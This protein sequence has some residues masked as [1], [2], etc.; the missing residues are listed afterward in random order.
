MLLLKLLTKSKCYHLH[1]KAGS[2]ILNLDMSDSQISLIHAKRP[3]PYLCLSVHLQLRTNKESPTSSIHLMWQVVIQ[4]QSPDCASHLVS[5]LTLWSRP[6]TLPQPLLPT[7]PWLLLG[8]VQPPGLVGTRTGQDRQNRFWREGMWLNQ[9][10]RSKLLAHSCLAP[11][12]LGLST[13]NQC[14]LCYD[15]R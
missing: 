5:P 15:S 14:L 10:E 4:L 11:L 9:E 13:H 8:K 3:P 1:E 12:Q 2:S 6:N 7:P